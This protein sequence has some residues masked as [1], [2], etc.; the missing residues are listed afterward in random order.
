L[1]PRVLPNLNSAAVRTAKPLKTLVPTP[2][3]EP[4]AY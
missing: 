1:L 2:G 4:G 3:F